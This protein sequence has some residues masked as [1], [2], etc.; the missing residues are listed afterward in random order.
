MYSTRTAL[1]SRAIVTERNVARLL[2]T[3]NGSSYP[4]QIGSMPVQIVLQQHSSSR[5]NFST[6]PPAAKVKEFFPEYHSPGIRK[7]KAAWS[8]PLYAPEDHT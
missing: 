3:L 8:H 4:V 2:K 5:R 1:H 6:T 7:T